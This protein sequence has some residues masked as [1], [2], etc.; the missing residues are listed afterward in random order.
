MRLLA[1]LFACCVAVATLLPLGGC[2]PGGSGMGD[3][4]LA[5]DALADLIVALHEDDFTKALPRIEVADGLV[6]I[7]HPQAPEYARMK[8]EERTELAR[9]LYRTMRGPLKATELTSHAAVKA[10]LAAGTLQ[11]MPQ[12]KVTVVRFTAHDTERKNRP[13][14][15]EAKMRWGLDSTWRAVSI[16]E[17][18]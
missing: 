15:F 7:G 6:A 2:S 1:A 17:A 5:R 10:A 4:E 12:L 18:R 11:P 8:P 13:L 9:E 16:Q 3:P 14:Q